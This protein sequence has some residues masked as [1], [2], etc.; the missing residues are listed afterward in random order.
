MRA[1]VSC[2][3]LPGTRCN[4][5][6]VPCAPFCPRPATLSAA[7]LL[8]GWRHLQADWH[9]G[10]PCLLNDPYK[11]CC[12]LVK[13]LT[14]DIDEQQGA[15]SGSL[16]ANGSGGPARATSEAQKQL[17]AVYCE[18]MALLDLPSSPFAPSSPSSLRAPPPYEAGL[19]HYLA[20][21]A[22]N[23]ALTSQDWSMAAY[24]CHFALQLFALPDVP[25]PSDSPHCLSSLSLLLVALLDELAAREKASSHAV[26]GQAMLRVVHDKRRRE[27]DSRSSGVDDGATDMLE[28]QAHMYTAS[29]RRHW[30]QAEVDKQKAERKASKK[31]RHKSAHQA[32]STQQWKQAKQGEL[33][34]VQQR[35]SSL[36]AQRRLQLNK[37]EQ[38]LAVAFHLQLDE[39]TRPL[40]EHIVTQQLSAATPVSR[41]MHYVEL[42]C[43]LSTDDELFVS[44]SFALTSAAF[45]SLHLRCW[46]YL[47]ER[48]WTAGTVLARG[49][50]SE[51]GQRLLAVG[52]RLLERACECEASEK[53][54]SAMDVAKVLA[55][56]SDVLTYV[57]ERDKRLA[58]DESS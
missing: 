45:P 41:Q 35:L 57:R 56:L 26:Y 47:C 10:T 58:R 55:Q 46:Q 49:G 51:L 36:L 16:A 50:A 27:A 43:M 40:A 14:D 7:Q 18:L 39:L 17:C 5:A 6:A 24:F 29:G 53:V 13:Q 34:D 28:M 23:A 31:R 48:C 11:V 37:C 25:V 20:C 44:A 33:D 15:F 19:L 12:A 3:S 22:R 9:C 1:A 2:M 38:L 42:L 21:V 8:A 4:V 32:S 54:G 30:A 52:I